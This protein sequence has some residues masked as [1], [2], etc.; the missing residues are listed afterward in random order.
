MA[1]AVLVERLAVHDE[2]AVALVRA[3]SEAGEDVVALVTEALEIGAR[4][5]DREQAEANAEW[6]RAEFEKSSR[7]LEA[8][9]V[10]KAKAVAEF[11][12][13]RVEQVFGAE[14]GQLAKELTRLFGDG[15]SEAVQHQ[16]RQVM[17][18][19][20]ARMR[21]DL[22]KQFSSADGSNPLADF[23]A[24]TMA[25]MKRAAEQQDLN[26]KAMGDQ[27]SELRLEVQKLQAEKQK[28]TEVAAEHDR[29]TAKGRPYEEAVFDA[30]DAVAGAQGDDCEAVGDQLGTGGRKG[31]V[32]VGIDACAGPARGRIV[33]EAKHSQVPRK[34]ALEEL[35]AAM[36]QRD[37]QYAVWVVP[38]E[39]LLPAKTLELREVNGDKMFVVFDPEDGSRLLLEVAYKLARARVLMA[40]GAADGVD[41]G[42]LQTEV[43]R[44]LMAMEDVR[45]IKAQ[46]TTAVGGI[47]QARQILDVMAARVREHLERIDNLVAVPG[48][49][50]RMPR[51]LDV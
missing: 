31:D 46:L 43:E 29:S 7:D 44:A 38:S 6:M 15:S 3:R 21:E 36:A 39:E 27:L 28:L 14:N 19:A 10:D 18:D 9:F 26:L 51:L 45:R 50:R 33:F 17:G 20:T 42:A 13:K 11:F 49:P 48:E 8:S 37:A 22:L 24:G 41:A 5:L 47:E 25:A 40:R 12:D 2:R 35:D 23:K 1:N 16:L 32:L 4:V 34:K 30:V